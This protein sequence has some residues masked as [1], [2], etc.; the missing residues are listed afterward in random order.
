MT[1]K[2]LEIKAVIFDFDGTLYDKKGF[3]KKLIL[4]DILNLFKLRA[5]RKARESLM[6]RE[7]PSSLALY[8]EMF[9]LMGGKKEK[10]RSWYFNTF[11]KRFVSVLSKQY[12][13]REG[14]D[15]LLSVLKAK[16]LSVAL[17]SDYAMIKE[18]L[19][20][21][22]VSPSY[23]DVIM[24]S[25]ETGALKPSSKSFLKCAEHMNADPS[26]TLVIGDREDT[27]G[28]GAKNAKMPYLIISS[29]GENDGDKISWDHLLQ[30]MLNA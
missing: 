8:D 11:Y 6:G 3:A 2:G 14:L 22:D 7:F 18:R 28:E 30:T 26:Q 24:S 17:L 5:S 23:F 25:E 12:E 10:Q 4:S 1:I 9:R 29:V 20:A 16:G 19:H 27:D 15:D 13:K 21:I